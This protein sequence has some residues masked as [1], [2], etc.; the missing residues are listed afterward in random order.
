[1][2]GW[3]NKREDLAAKFNAI[4]Q[5]AQDT[6]GG[7]PMDTKS[8]VTGPAQD[9]EL[10][11]YE[12]DAM[13][14]IYNT[15][16]TLSGAARSRV[17][18]YVTNFMCEMDQRDVMMGLRREEETARLRHE[19][20]YPSSGMTDMEAAAANAR[21]QFAQARRADAPPPSDLPYPPPREQP[22]PPDPPQHVTRNYPSY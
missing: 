15:L 10:L 2:N 3:M 11:K 6:L 7:E 9:E 1:M 19:P 4:I 16:A 20:E 5:Q 12:M 21:Q 22:D 17:M 18:V 14:T 13:Q 8:K